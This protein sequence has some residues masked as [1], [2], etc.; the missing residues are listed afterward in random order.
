MEIATA[1]LNI[2]FM[3]TLD[4]FL[5]LLRGK[6]DFRKVKTL[7]RLMLVISNAKNPFFYYHYYL[8]IW[9]SN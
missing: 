4:F 6:R 7:L 1:P 3:V 5:F 9:T 2:A 8:S